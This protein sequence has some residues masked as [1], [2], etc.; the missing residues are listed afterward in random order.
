MKRIV[1]L[2]LALILALS[3]L[4]C[5]G[6]GGSS[7]NPM[8]QVATPTFTP[9]PGSYA[10]A[11]AVTINCLTAGATIRFTTD[12]TPPTT[13]SPAYNN[14]QIQVAVSTTINAIAEKQGM[15]TSGVATAAYSIGGGSSACTTPGDTMSINI[16]PSV[17]MDFI[18]VTPGTFSMGSDDGSDWNAQPAHQVTISSGYWIGKYEVTQTQWSAITGNNPSKFQGLTDSENRPVERVMWHDVK[19]FLSNLNAATGKTFRLP[20][21]AE[22]EFAARGGTLSQGYTYSGANDLN[23][24]GWYWSNSPDGTKAVGTKGVN[25]LGIYD[26]SGNVYEWVEDDWHLYTDATRPDDGTAWI[27]NPRGLARV[28]RGG[29]WIGFAGDQRVASRYDFFPGDKGGDLGFRLALDE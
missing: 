2:V 24:V 7:S 1:R 12:G 8:Q 28:F 15:L 10:T 5:G 3:V 14:A 20:S 25:E 26:M 17:T 13:A 23:E 4:S 11:Q 9:T 27:D 29:S 19:S 6:G 16:T 21:E 18:C 22:W